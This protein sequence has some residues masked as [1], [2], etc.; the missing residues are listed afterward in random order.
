MKNQIPI[1]AWF[2]CGA[3]SAVACKIALANYQNVRVVYIDTGSGHKDNIRFIKDCEI[4]YNQKIEIIH[5]TKYK[6]V[7]DV[8]KKRKF[9]NG[10]TGASCTYHLKKVVRYE[11]EKEIQEWKGQVWGFDFCAKE[12]NRAIRFKE[13]NP[14]TKPLYPLIEKQLTKQDALAMLIQA[15]IEV[16]IMYKKGYHN[17][18]YIGCVKGGMGYWN[19]IRID[20]PQVFN[21]MAQLEREIKSTCLMVNGKQ[22]YLDSLEPDRG[23][24]DSEIT[25][26]CSLFCAIEFEN[27]LDKRVEKILGGES[28]RNI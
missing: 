26:G 24:L 14:D 7:F 20:F 6:N 19:R 17:N 5:S 21:E 3:T 1:I 22:I 18:N 15:G 16:P 2:S 9:I 27:L 8:I 25:P 4:W 10:P 13:Q 28:I 11:Y 23:N 12:I